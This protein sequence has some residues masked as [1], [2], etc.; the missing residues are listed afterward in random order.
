[1][2][3]LLN[4]ASPSRMPV[5][6]VETFIPRIAAFDAQRTN[7]TGGSTSITQCRFLLFII[8]GGAENW[9]N[10]ASEGSTAG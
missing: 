6:P 2:F 3:S 1:M 7:L 5:S 8:A 10:N 4:L 9:K